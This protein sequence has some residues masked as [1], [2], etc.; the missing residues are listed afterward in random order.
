M[1]FAFQF[2]NGDQISK[3]KKIAIMGM[4]M[5]PNGETE[6]NRLGDSRKTL[7]AKH[8]L[9]RLANIDVYN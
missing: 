2:P 5:L 7:C 9:G 8:I 6:R 1:D 3:S 4:N